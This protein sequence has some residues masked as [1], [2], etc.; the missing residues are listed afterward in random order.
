[1]PWFE[2]ERRVVRA[3]DLFMRATIEEMSAIA[4]EKGAV[5][6]FVALDLVGPPP[7]T[8]PP[9]LEYART[10]GMVVFDLL[11]VWQGRDFKALRVGS[12]DT[13]PNGEGNRVIAERLALMI[14]EHAT[15]LGIGAKP[16]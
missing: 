10:N 15:E 5:P 6:V 13:H 12:W 16:H 7:K 1:M 4:R 3:G 2:A 14:Q 8:V 11:D 9:A